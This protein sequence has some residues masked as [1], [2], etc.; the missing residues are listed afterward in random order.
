MRK[1]ITNLSIEKKQLSGIIMPPKV[2]LGFII[3][4][5]LPSLLQLEGIF[6]RPL[7]HNVFTHF[8]YKLGLWPIPMTSLMGS[9]DSHIQS[10]AKPSQIRKISITI[11][12]DK[13]DAELFLLLL[14]SVIK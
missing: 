5:Y 4:R 8:R 1:K 9:V 6:A 14:D 7:A 12:H 3:T 11:T 2:T 10:Q 13:F